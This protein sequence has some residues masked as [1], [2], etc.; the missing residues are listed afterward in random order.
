MWGGDWSVRLGIFAVILLCVSRRHLGSG[1][2]APGQWLIP[3]YVW[4]IPA[5]GC[6]RRTAGSGVWCLVILP[7][8]YREPKC[9]VAGLRLQVCR[10]SSNKRPYPS[11]A[12]P[13][14]QV[15]R[16]WLQRNSL[17]WIRDSNLP[18]QKNWT[19]LVLLL[20]FIS[21][22]VSWMSSATSSSIP[23]GAEVVLLHPER[24]IPVCLTLHCLIHQFP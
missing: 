18:L 9:Q 20:I 23:I 24:S 8:H 13:R 6:R 17:S 14:P 19:D 7:A 11:S 15:P 12:K 4:N 21:T 16:Y 22:Y 5:L 3:E 2:V 10:S 1:H